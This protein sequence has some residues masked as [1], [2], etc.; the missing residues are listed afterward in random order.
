MRA[1]FAYGVS[2]FSIAL[3]LGFWLVFPFFSFFYLLLFIAI[4]STPT[5]YVY[6]RGA[7]PEEKVASTSLKRK[8][9]DAVAIAF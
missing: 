6:V 4:A 2:F 8:D 5:A 3:L 9:L 7:D 1:S